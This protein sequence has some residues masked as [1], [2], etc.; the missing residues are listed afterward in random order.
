MKPENAAR[1][2]AVSVEVIALVA[3]ST[4]AM[5]AQQDVRGTADRN[6]HI[7]LKQ[8]IAVTTGE[9]PFEVIVE[10]SDGTRR[11]DVDV[12]V[13]FVMAARPIK[14]IPETR[15]DLTLRRAGDGKYM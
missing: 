10:G 12:V 7:S 11:N 13:S 1:K 2:T 15:T 4:V 5:S 9:N 3:L 8:P 14:R 6:L